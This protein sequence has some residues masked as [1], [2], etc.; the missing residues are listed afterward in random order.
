[1]QTRSRVTNRNHMRS[2]VQAAKRI[3][4]SWNSRALRQEFRSKR[5]GNCV[6]VVL[7]DVLA[8]IWNEVL[9]MSASLWVQTVRARKLVCAVALQIENPDCSRSHTQN[10]V[11]PIGR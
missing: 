10:L 5:L 6:D 11:Q 2:R 3:F 7:D 1:M 4:K 9:H 8:A